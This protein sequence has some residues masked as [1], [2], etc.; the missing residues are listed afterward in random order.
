MKPLLTPRELATLAI[1]TALTAVMAQIAFPLPFTPVPISFGLVAVYTAGLM[2]KPKH[3]VLT[4]LCYLLLGA[5]GAPVFGG[6]R[7][8]PAA[9]FGATGGYLLLSPAV[10]AV[11]SMA[12]NRRKSLQSEARQGR[13]ALVFKAGIFMCI[14]LILLYLGG[15]LWLCAI[16][17]NTFKA[18]LALAV[19]PYIPLDVLKI[20]FCTAVMLPLRARL[21]RMHLLLPDE[22]SE[23]GNP[24]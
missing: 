8:G 12:L 7:G 18:G 19:Y 4:Q 17:G 15:T 11:V 21:R 5:V 3:A 13:G 10:A 6:F 14:A 2:L 16:T 22:L 9:L 24:S 20:A 23:K 1:F